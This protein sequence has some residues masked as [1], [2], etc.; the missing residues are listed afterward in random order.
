MEDAKKWESKAMDDILKEEN[1][2]L[3]F[4]F[5]DE[6]KRGEKSFVLKYV[7][8]I[9]LFLLRLEREEN[10]GVKYVIGIQPF[11]INVGR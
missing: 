3:V 8:G 5:Q 4:E 6:D 11:F 2:K 9:Q 1:Y 7:I 10:F